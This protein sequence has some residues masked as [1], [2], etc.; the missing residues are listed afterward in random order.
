[1]SDSGSGSVAFEV[2]PA[3]MLNLSCLLG[4]HRLSKYGA[5]DLVSSSYV[6]PPPPSNM[7]C[8]LLSVLSLSPNAS[9]GHSSAAVASVGSALHILGSTM[10]KGGCM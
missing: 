8:V 5:T 2:L 3:D 9:G 6:N 4:L 1:M 10:I 7:G